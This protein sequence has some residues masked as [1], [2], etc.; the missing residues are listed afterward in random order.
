MLLVCG[1]GLALVGWFGYRTAS[2][3][4]QSI[5]TGIQQQ[6]EQMQFASVWQAPQPGAGPDVLFP[7]NVNAWRLASHD[8]DSAIVELAI[9]RDG[10]HARYESGVTG[11]DV[12]AYEV[13]AVEQAALFQDAADAIEAVNYTKRVQGHIDDGTSHRMTFEFAP[14]ETYGRMWWC[15]GWLF[16]LKSDNSTLDL[17]AFQTQYLSAVADRAAEAA[18]A[19]GMEQPVGPADETAPD[20]V[21]DPAGETAPDEPA[22]PA[23]PG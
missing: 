17:D 2:Q 8:D 6:A 20:A 16:V 4:G 3:V 19:D 14:P 5:S 22:T 15:R 10:R 7:E 1:G 23:E 12:Y 11:I 18:A 13:P 9:E 21:Q